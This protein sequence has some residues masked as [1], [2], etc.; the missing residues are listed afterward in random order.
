MII[1]VYNVKQPFDEMQVKN[2]SPMLNIQ[3]NACFFTNI[4]KL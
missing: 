4:Y 1:P 3:P 2:C